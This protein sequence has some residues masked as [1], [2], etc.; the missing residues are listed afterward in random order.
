MSNGGD[1][2][3]RLMRASCGVK[4][5]GRPDPCP[6]G[7]QLAGGRVAEVIVPFNVQCD[8][9][10]QTASVGKHPDRA[11]GAGCRSTGMKRA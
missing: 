8:A 3:A 6:Q 9:V 7:E 10:M 2:P 11:F 5:E 1:G 4:S